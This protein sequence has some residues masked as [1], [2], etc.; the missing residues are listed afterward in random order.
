MPSW[1][2]IA[3]TSLIAVVA[4]GLFTKLAPDSIYDTL[5]LP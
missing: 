3:V 5:Y 1:K 2:A 4:V